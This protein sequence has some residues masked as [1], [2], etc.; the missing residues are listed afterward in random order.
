MWSR[1]LQSR[2]R[3]EDRR[4]GDLS[5]MWNKQE[6][7]SSSYILWS[8][9]LA[10]EEWR[11]QRAIRTPRSVSLRATRRHLGSVLKRGCYGNEVVYD[12]NGGGLKGEREYS[13]IF[14]WTTSLEW[15]EE[16]CGSLLTSTGM[17]LERQVTELLVHSL[18][19][20]KG[21]RRE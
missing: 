12:Q 8:P 21:Y 15:V 4:R 19:R 18:W 6:K 13:E 11:W 20:G 10:R 16:T 9:L 17:L 5:F 3:A 1:P 2:R 7:R 14:S